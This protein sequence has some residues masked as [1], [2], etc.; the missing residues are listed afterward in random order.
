MLSMG[1]RFREDDVS[2][3]NKIIPDSSAPARE[4]V[5]ANGRNDGL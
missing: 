1:R 2:K 5:S 3:V 4:V